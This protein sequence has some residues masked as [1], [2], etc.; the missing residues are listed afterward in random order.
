MCKVYHLLCGIFTVFSAEYHIYFY[1]LFGFDCNGCQCE[2]LLYNICLISWKLFP[3]QTHCK[4]ITNCKLE[5]VNFTLFSNLLL[6]LGACACGVCPVPAVCAPCPPCVPR[7]C[8]VC[9]VPAACALCPSWPS[10]CAFCVAVPTTYAVGAPPSFH[11]SPTT[12]K[13][14]TC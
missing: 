6:E 14:S 8:R 11:T 7:A 13:P 9:P 2:T 10:G 4:K 1:W 5:E 3:N 12:G